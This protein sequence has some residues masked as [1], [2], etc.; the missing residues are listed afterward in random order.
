MLKVHFLL[1]YVNNSSDCVLGSECYQRAGD[2]QSLIYLNASFVDTDEALT[3]TAA[4]LLTH[5]SLHISCIV[6]APR[7]MAE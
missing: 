4:A 3:G 2:L 7:W 5:C 1:L 6:T